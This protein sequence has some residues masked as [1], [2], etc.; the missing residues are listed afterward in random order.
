MDKEGASYHRRMN[1]V[2]QEKIDELIAEESD[3]K[4]RLMLMVMSNINKSIVANTE[5]TYAIYSEVKVLKS[6][7]ETHVTAVLAEKNQTAGVTRTLKIAGPVLW[8]IMAGVIANMYHHYDNFQI[9]TNKVLSGISIQLTAIETRIN[10]D[11]SLPI[12]KNFYKQ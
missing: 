2:Q 11:N 10:D 5:L 12:N 8:A 4:I 9:D 1:D 3:G 6:D 7:L